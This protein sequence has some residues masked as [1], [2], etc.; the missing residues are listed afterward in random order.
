MSMLTIVPLTPI[1]A[2]TDAEP[3]RLPMDSEQAIGGMSVACSGI[4]EAKSDPR[5]LEFPIR[6]EFANDKH[7]HL[8]GASVSISTA[9]AEPVMEVSCMGAWLL[10]RP[11]DQATYRLEARIIGE[12]APPQSRTIKT[13]AHGQ[14]RVVITFPGVE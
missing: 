13:P 11:A 14:T 3:L 5:W 12:T 10:L 9:R 4:G 2:Q 8:I 1:A 7:E 6:V